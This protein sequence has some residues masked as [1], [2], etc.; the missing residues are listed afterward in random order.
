MLELPT[1]QYFRSNK[2]RAAHWAA[3]YVI[4]QSELSMGSPWSDIIM[5]LKVSGQLLP[6]ELPMCSPGADIIM[7]LHKPWAAP[8]HWAAHCFSGQPMCSTWAAHFSFS[9]GLFL[10]SSY[11]PCTRLFV[12]FLLNW[13]SSE[14]RL[15]SWSGHIVFVLSVRLFVCLSVYLSVVNSNQD[16]DL[17]NPIMISF[18]YNIKRDFY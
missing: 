7:S 17:H 16:R 15:S 1:A 12:V 4:V 2:V 8:V 9:Y 13:S 14:S 5:R 11:S 3:N 18:Q 6:T 10:F